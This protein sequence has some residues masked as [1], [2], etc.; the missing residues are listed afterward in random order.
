MKNYQIVFT[1]PAKAELLEVG[2]ADPGRGKVLV[3]TA[4]STVS[5]GTERA[6]LIGDPNISPAR[7]SGEGPARFPRKLGYSSSGIVEAVGEDV[8]SVCPGDRVVVSWG[9]HS[10]FQVMDERNMHLL[11]PENTL[12]EGALVMIGTFPLAAIRKV[13]LEIGES[14]LVMGQGILGQMAVMLLRTAGA[15]PVLAADPSPEKRKRALTL[16]A[17][18]A[19]DPFAPDFEEQVRKAAGGG[20]RTAIEVTGNGKALDQ[21]LDCM[22]RFG[23]V[24]LLGCTRHSDFTIDY[25]RK[26]HGPGISLIGAHTNARPEVESSPG[27]WTTR[28]DIRALLRLSACG[29]LN[30][31]GMVEEVRSPA[32][33]P[34]VYARLAEE[35]QFPVVQFDWSRLEEA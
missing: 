22:A 14:A 19:F 7:G 20:V 8:R 32:E 6:N 23:R 12:T 31:G 2:T 28:D 5:S 33:A 18:A 29:R 11:E 13:R 35:K 21:A 17:D 30:L 3:K 25:Y 4:F 16:G 24:A 9:T 26:V 1:S 27:M 10:R 34:E 15:C